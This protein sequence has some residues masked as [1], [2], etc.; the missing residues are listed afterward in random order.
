ME[1]NKLAARGK[2]I[3]PSGDVYEGDL[4]DGVPH[5]KGTLTFSY[6]DVYEGDFVDGKFHG[7]GTLTLPDGTVYSGDFVEGRHVDSG[8]YVRAEEDLLYSDAC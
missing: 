5:G 8:M 1:K 7:K 4:I 6:G 2:E 3:S